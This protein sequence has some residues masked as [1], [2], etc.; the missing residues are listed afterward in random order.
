MDIKRLD[1]QVT[2][3]EQFSGAAMAQLAQS[4]VKVVVCNRPE[5]ESE[6]QPTH[7]AMETA[8]EENGMEY[9]VIPFARGQMTLAHCQQFAELLA[10]G[11]K[12]HAFCRTGNRS[13]N[14][15]AG[16]RILDGADK[17]ALLGCARA[18]GFD[19]SGVLVAI[20][21]E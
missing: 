3:S 11:D 12:V 6:D 19:V 21:P 1:D 16:A 18:A 20:D 2:V 4:G 5:G 17:K 7:A 10:R 8:A 9:V 13:C 15:W 14:L